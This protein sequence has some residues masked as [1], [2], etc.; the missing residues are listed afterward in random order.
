MCLYMS[1]NILEFMQISTDYILLS[2]ENDLIFSAIAFSM[3]IV[4]L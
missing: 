2:F 3:Q 1:V 4:S